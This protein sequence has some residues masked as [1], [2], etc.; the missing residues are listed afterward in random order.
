MT[1]ETYSYSSFIKILSDSG[2]LSIGARKHHDADGTYVDVVLLYGETC[3]EI[4]LLSC[5]LD[6]PTR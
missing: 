1:P 6:T 2:T 5:M 3:L 4:T